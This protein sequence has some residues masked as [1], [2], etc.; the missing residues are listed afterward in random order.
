MNTIC[1]L[2]CLRMELDYMVMKMRIF[3][4]NAVIYANFFSLAL[5]KRQLKIPKVS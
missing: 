2:R 1:L 3:E 4:A 5:V